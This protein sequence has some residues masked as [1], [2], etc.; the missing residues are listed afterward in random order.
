MKIS[1]CWLFFLNTPSV[2]LAQ[3]D[4]IVINEISG[5]GGNI[6]AGN[7]AIVELAGPAGAEIGCMVIT[8]TEWAIV[9]PA[10]TTIPADG[11]FLIACSERNNV[12]NGFY[13]GI[14]TGLSCD[15]CDF[16][17][18]VIDFDVCDDRNANYVSPSVYT[19]YGFT[20]DNQPQAGNKDGDQ[21]LLFRPDGTPHDGVYWGASDKT[22]ANGGAMTVGGASGNAGTASDHVSVQINHPYTLGDNDENGVV[23]DNLN[24]HRGYRANGAN[25]MGV[26]W[27]PAGNDDLGNPVLFG[28]Q[29]NVPP[30]DCNADQKVY[31][32]PALSNS[33]WVN[34]GLNLTSCNSTHIRLNDTSPNG[35]SHQEPRSSTTSSHMDD[36]DLN[37][38]W[39]AFAA[40]VLVPSSI[41]ATIAKAQWQVTNHPNPS[42]PNDA[43]SW[44]FFYDI[45]SGKVEITEKNVVN[46][47]VCQAQAVSFE[48]KVYN[49]QHVEP[50]MRSSKIAGSFIRDENGN[51]QNWTI[52][53]VGH[54]ITEGTA[55]SNN[56]G[57]TTFNFTSNNLAVGATHSFTLVWDDFTDCCGSSN[58]NTVVNQSRA[59]ECYEKIKVNITVSETITVSDNMITCPGDFSA[60][61]GL[62]DFSQ[63]LTS[64][65]AIMEYQLKS[66]VTNGMEENTGAVVATNKTGV[67]QLS[68]TLTPPLAIIVYDLA[69]CG[70]NQ[71]I[72]IADDCRNAPPCP[73]PNGATISKNSV[74]PDEDFTLSIDASASTD[75]PSGG[76]IDWYYGNVG[77]DP[78]KNEGT[79]LG[80]SRVTTTLPP[81]PTTGPVINEVLVDA[82]DND[83]NGGEFIEIA[84]VPDTDLSCYILTD[85][86]DEIILPSGTKI[87][88][89]GFLLIAS[90]TN[91]NAPVS[92]IDVDLDNCGCFSDPTGANGGADLQFTNHSA[93]NGEFLFMYDEGGSFVDGILWGGPSVGGGNNHPDATAMHTLTITPVGCMPIATV[94]RS[95][96]NYTDVNI[97]SGSNG[98]SIERA[99]DVTGAWQTTDDAGKFTAGATNSGALPTIAVTDLTT[100]LGTDLC[101]QTIEI[102]GVV[103][104]TT[105]TNICSEDQVTTS[106]LSLTITCPEATLQAGDKNLCLPVDDNEVLAT[107]DLSSGS[108]NY[109]VLVDIAYNGTVFSLAKNGVAHP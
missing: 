24:A 55:N 7:D 37:A 39:V 6:E 28:N 20:L 60:N 47:S 30:G 33:V 95:G 79:L 89:N 23:N 96:Q 76:T 78:F 59:H 52:T 102:K 107:V 98:I 51:D 88:E 34:L 36:P 10:G 99:T 83:G 38:D 14:K 46:L 74:C 35:N 108:G 54:S 67:F 17:G 4:N 103:R 41:D 43:D 94:T 92:K 53:T 82:A 91:T 16:P 13:T 18:L 22:K 65:D 49:Y 2:I 100:N 72:T 105:I 56:D 93:S 27:M 63:F 75:L 11:V 58:N 5:D 70:T 64:P 57:I 1:F 73:D 61:V 42:E 29:L 8:N 21:V 85:G 26:Y 71:V 109:D 69:N 31:T 9:L 80:Q 87:P 50:K 62:I 45:G 86:D 32:A 15:V 81:A 19:T 97:K 101:N 90:S 25:A 68:N 3:Y 40:S 66:S 48:L 104:P 77:F 12:S 106:V 84:G 44:D